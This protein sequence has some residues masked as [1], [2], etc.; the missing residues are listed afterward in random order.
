M[1]LIH[2]LHLDAAT[3]MASRTRW[4]VSF[5]APHLSRTILL[6]DAVSPLWTSS[7]LEANIAL[8][9]ATLWKGT[10]NCSNNVLPVSKPTL[11]PQAA[12]HHQLGTSNV[13]GGATLATLQDRRCQRFCL[14][15]PTL[16]RWTLNMSQT[17]T[18][19]QFSLDVSPVYHALDKQML[20]PHA[21]AKWPLF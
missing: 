20:P 15:L 8:L 10:R 9:I 6:P 13:V 3:P 1:V 4:I 21:P 7:Q 14:Q 16:P 18:A 2:I 11:V 12:T 19:F 17:L 5:L